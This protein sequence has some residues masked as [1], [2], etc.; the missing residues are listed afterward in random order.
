MIQDIA[1]WRLRIEFEPHAPDP[2]DFVFDFCADGL[3]LRQ[4]DSLTFPTVAEWHLLHAQDDGTSLIFAFRFEHELDDGREMRFF[5]VRRPIS[6]L[7]LLEQEGWERI[8]ARAL[9]G[10]GWGWPAFAGITAFHLHNWYESRRF[11]GRCGTATRPGDRERSLVCPQCGAVEYPSIPPSV[12]TAV[13]DGNRLLLTRYN[14]PGAS[15]YVLVAGYVEA[16][17]TAEQAAIREVLEETGVR[18]KNLR[19]LGSQPWGL[20]GTLS[21]AFAAELDGSD[22]II[23]DQEELA[24]ALWM[25]RED[26]P[27]VPDEESITMKIIAGFCRGDW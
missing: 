14:R 22:K 8:P 4:G 17:E 25:K 19:Y 23:C 6:C 9:W 15:R 21:L 10:Y 1:P 18:I 13:T 2:G 12:L 27:P 3:L 16:G 11:C 7:P 5:L 26:I 20:S 24:E